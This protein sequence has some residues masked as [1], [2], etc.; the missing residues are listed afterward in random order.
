MAK[1]CRFLILCLILA[2]ALVIW[3]GNITAIEIKDITVQIICQIIL[4]VSILRLLFLEKFAIPKDPVILLTVLYG[5]LM[6]LSYLSTNRVSL[7]AKALIPQ[8]YGVLTFILV[9]H[10]FGKKDIRLLIG[11]CII[12]AVIASLYGIAQYTNLDPLNW[13]IPG[14]FKRGLMVSFFGH[15]NYFAIFLLLMIPLS[16]FQALTS[17]KKM[18]A[19]IFIVSTG[20]MVLALVLSKSRGAIISFFLAVLIGSILYVLK[21]R[22]NFLR[23]AKTRKILISLILLSFLLVLFLPE[24]IRRDF[25]GSAPNLVIRFTYYR[26]ALEVIG[27]NPFLGVGPGNFMISYPLNKKHKVYTDDPNQVLNHVHNDFLEI[28]AEYGLVALLAYLGILGCFIKD[29]VKRYRTADETRQQ[30]T[31]ILIL[32]SVVSY[33]ICSQATV[34]GRYI[35][36]SFYFWTVLGIGIL[37]LSPKNGGGK[38]LF[39]NRLKTHRKLSIL[40]VLCVCFIFAVS[41]NR[42]WKN[43]LSDVYLKTALD[44]SMNNKFQQASKLTDRAVTLRPE[45][46]EAHYQKG[47]VFF[48]Q[49]R[50][51]QALDAYQTVHRMMPNYINVAF[52]TASCHYRKRDWINA[53]RMADLSHRCYP[54]YEPPVLMLANCYYYL[55]QPRK[56]ISYCNILLEKRPNHPKALKLKKRLEDIL[57]HK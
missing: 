55:R 6:I 51:D 41:I 14:Y 7:N 35:S 30:V 47:F 19:V 2:V 56:A 49:N 1:V 37:Y 43:Y 54:E 5:I 39:S 29:W 12:P 46:I 22:G 18:S 53:I 38:I 44:L 25:K 13:M 20:I 26:A 48:S 28:W 16:I 17:E 32:S 45:S 8:I 11:F 50:I 52:N 15:K 21:N 24:D 40:A 31:L 23:E 57:G 10:Y 3:N 36:S 42:V 9:I 27:R 4:L 33:T 34:A